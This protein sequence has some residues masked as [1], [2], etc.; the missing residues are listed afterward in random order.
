MRNRG[1]QAKPRLPRRLGLSD[2][3]AGV[4]GAVIDHDDLKVTVRLRGD[5]VEGARQVILVVEERDDDADDGGFI[6]H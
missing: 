1:K 6:C 4:G 5:G 3:G 2:R